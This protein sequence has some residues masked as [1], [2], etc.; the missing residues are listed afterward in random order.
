MA[1]EPLVAASLPSPPGRL[2][3]VTRWAG[4]TVK[5]LTNIL[6]RVTSTLNAVEARGTTIATPLA[7]STVVNLPATGNVAGD[8]RFCSN[9]TGGPTVVFWNGTVWKRVQDLATAA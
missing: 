1:R 4:D 3:G 7:S 8:L 6:F 9:E 2:T 5:A